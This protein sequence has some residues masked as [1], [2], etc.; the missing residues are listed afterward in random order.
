[1]RLLFRAFGRAEIPVAYSQ[2]F[3]P[4]PRFEFCPPLKVGMAGL[5]ELFEVELLGEIDI[6]AAI[7][8]LNGTLPSGVGFLGARMLSPS[9]PPLSKAISGAE[10]AALLPKGWALSPG[11]LEAFLSRSTAPVIGVREGRTGVT[12]A[13]PGVRALSLS[14]GDDG[15]RELQIGVSLPGARPTDVLKALTGK[16]EEELK[17]A[18]WRRIGFVGEGL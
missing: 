4:H 1:M 15:R 18:L 7:G 6:P 11:D 2:G 5:D 3:S 9:D 10:Y 12:D 8:T 13:R 17:G 16:P 14:L